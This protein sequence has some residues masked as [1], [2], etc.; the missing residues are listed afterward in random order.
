MEGERIVGVVY[1]AEGQVGRM[2]LTKMYDLVFTDHRL[3]GIVTA[4]SGAAGLAGY[5]LGGVIGGAIASSISKGGSSSKR[6]SYAGMPLENLI[7]QDEANFGVP[8]SQIENPEIKGM[9]TKYLHMKVA[10][11]KAVFKLAKEQVPQVESLIAMQTRTA[12]R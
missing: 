3:V 12:R 2:A 9:L 4:K 1:D 7:V 5:A 10:G 8:Y 11:K 6:A